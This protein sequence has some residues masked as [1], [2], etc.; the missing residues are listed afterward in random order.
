MDFCF[1]C[2]RVDIWHL[3]CFKILI[4]IPG[5]KLVMAKN[6]KKMVLRIKLQFVLLKISVLNIQRN[7]IIYLVSRSCLNKFF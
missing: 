6:D 4:E 7:L 5:K 3:G 2:K 1:S